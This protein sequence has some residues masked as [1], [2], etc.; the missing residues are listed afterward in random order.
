MIMLMKKIVLFV[1]LALLCAA[2]AA[3]QKIGRDEGVLRVIVPSDLAAV[4]SDYVND[5]QAD[6]YI[7]PF[8]IEWD[9]S[10]DV[11]GLFTDGSAV[12]CAHGV[13]AGSSVTF[14]LLPGNYYVGYN[15]SINSCVTV[16]V[17]PGK[18]VSVEMLHFD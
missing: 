3:C 18:E 1:A 7:Y 8:G 10:G 5:E 17:L 11:D 6:I 15:Y 2:S 13:A 14:T 4:P 12:A 9:A 16:Q